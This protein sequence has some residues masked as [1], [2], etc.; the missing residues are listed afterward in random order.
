MAGVTSERKVN[1]LEN[2]L[3]ERDRQIREL[4]DENKKLQAEI[5]GFSNDIL[6]LQEIVTE[7]RRLNKEFAGTNK[8][9]KKLKKRYERDMKKFM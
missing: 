3:L 1:V 2:L 6:E 8:E 7:T 4:Q 5:E 9:M